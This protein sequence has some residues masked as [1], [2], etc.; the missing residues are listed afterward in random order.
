MLLAGLAALPAHAQESDLA[1]CLTIADMAERVRCYDTLAR[2]EQDQA[3]GEDTPAAAQADVPPAP[4]APP[5]APASRPA[6]PAAPTTPAAANPRDDFGLSAAEREVRRPTEQ[7]QLDSI[8]TTISSART[9]GAGYWQFATEE[10]SVW[11]MTEV[12]RS[13][14]PPDPGDQVTIRRGTLGS[15]YIDVDN[16][17]ALPIRRVD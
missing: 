13:F 8:R 17:P 6:A 12:R 7:R 10:G 9:V 1:R 11:R 15:Y 2:A 16:Q 5:A 3:Q 4:A 14:R